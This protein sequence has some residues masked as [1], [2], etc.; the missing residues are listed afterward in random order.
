MPDTK[1]DKNPKICLSLRKIIA[2]M[3]KVVMY[4]STK[5]DAFERAEVHFRVT[6]GVGHQY[7]VKST[8][9]I[10]RKAFD[11]KRGI[12]VPR[13]ASEEQRELLRAKK[14]LSEMA[15]LLYEVASSASPGALS[16]E[17]LVSALDKYLHP[18][19]KEVGGERRLVDAVREYPI[20]KRLSEE[21][22]HNFAAKARL[23]ERYEIY[24]GRVVR[25]ADIT[26]DELKELQYFI[27][28]EHS[29]LNNP[30]YAEA[31]TQVERSRIPQRR[32][33]NTVVGIL[34][35]IRT[36]LKRC[37]EQ[38]EVATY[39][40][41]TFSVGEEHYGT[42]Y[43]ITIDERNI[44]YGTDMGALN[45]Q[46]DIFVFQCLIG[47]RVGDLMRLTRHNLI[48][49]A[50]H[51]VPRK[52]KEGRPVTVRVPLN[53]TAR[54]IVE[55]YADEE[56]ESLLPFISSQ[57]YNVAI[58]RIF[59]LAGITRLVTIINP[60][61]GEEEQRPINEIASSHLARRTFIGNLYKKVKDPNLIGAL[62]G[63]KEGSRAFA[64]YRD[65]D[66][67]IRKELVDMLK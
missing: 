58:K 37:F 8:V 54:E 51:Y 66:D 14:R 29:L 55:R 28:N 61:T 67:D 18:D 56:R 3:A 5:N 38:G 25:L 59:T 49:G 12:V 53:D 41:A 42:P 44:I 34:D 60:T 31:Y 47:C 39:A 2:G 32:G 1:I 33:R 23:L 11:D 40:F 27:E 22:V 52:T 15:T 17:M 35:M 10:P 48:N 62:S 43:Y 45:V 6:A 30:A 63:H 65:I 24:R 7:R 4:L 36:V 9:K 16:K 64:R 26:V 19:K 50:I 46:R 20:E 21:R 13:I 57:K